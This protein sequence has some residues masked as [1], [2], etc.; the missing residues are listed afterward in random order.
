MLGAAAVQAQQT[1]GKIIYERTMELNIRF[2]GLDEGLQQQIPRTRV[3]KIQVLFAN[4]K[5]VRRQLPPEESDEQAFQS[6]V[7]EGRQMQVRMTMAGADDVTFTDHNNGTL[8]EQRE[9]GTKTFIIGDS[10]QKLNWKLTGETRTILG[11][12]CQQA[13]AQ[14]I[15]TRFSMSMANGEMKR[16][17]VAD[18]AR[19]TAWFTTAIPVSVSPE[20]QGQL[21]GLVLALD[22]NNG[23]TVY[24]AVELSPKVDLALVKEPSKGKKVNRKE[25]DDERAKL[26]KDM[27]INTSGGRGMIRISN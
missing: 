10:V 26:M 16:E 8:V 21:P 12:T 4:G 1:E 14:R 19:I 23:R 15:S 13:T 5:S 9:L 24:K 27:Q 11:Y 2:Q 20:F 7:G 18:T 22:I 17:E 3:D 6:A 25:F